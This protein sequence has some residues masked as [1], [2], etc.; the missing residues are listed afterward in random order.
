MSRR[1]VIVGGGTAGWLTAGIF[2]A[3]HTPASE[4][5]M[6]TRIV[7]LESPDVGSLGVGEGTW[8][9]MRD[10]LR[11]IG[12][13]EVDFLRC[14]DAS[15]KQGSQFINWHRGEGETYYH[16]FSLPRS[17]AEINLAAHWQAHR[18]NISFTDAVC[19]QGKVCDQGL[20]PKQPQTPEY[21]FNLNY[22]YHLNA[23]KFAQLLH[24]HCVDNLGVEYQQGHVDRVVSSD[25]G[26]IAELQLA[27]G[28]SIKGDL[29]IDCTGFAARLIGQHYQIPFISR[30][31]ALFNDTALAVQADHARED[32]PVA[33]CTKATAQTKGWIWDIA[34]PSRRGIGYVFSSQHTSIEQAEATLARYLEADPELARNQPTPR[35]IQFQPGHRETFWYR[36][37]VAIGV[38]AGFIE[39]LEATALVLI[40]KSADWISHQL[41]RDRAAMVPLA[42]RFNEMT[43]QRWDKVIDFLKLHYVLTRRQDSD[44]WCDHLRPE[45]IPTSLR[46]SL[47]LWRTQVPWHHDSLYRFDLFSSASIQYVLYGMQFQTQVNGERYRGWQREQQVASRLFHDSASQARTLTASLPSNRELLNRI[48]ETSKTR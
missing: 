5:E 2:A 33:S 48:R 8:P 47:N 32:S 4:S 12:I 42:K 17:Y 41:P 44:Y 43:R 27:S 34:L 46:E 1:V 25:N 14:C 21:A 26:D 3:K 38:S 35:R 29:F 7:L 19:P 13:S 16:P 6:G 10:T 37:C 39:P 22:G 28:E 31:D 45:S 20:A 11:Q 24:R 15:F 18:E 36:N 9:T 40:E 30:R 23:G